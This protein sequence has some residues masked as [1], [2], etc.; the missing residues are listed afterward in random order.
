MSSSS[1]FAII[2]AAIIILGRIINRHAEKQ[3]NSDDASREFDTEHDF[4]SEDTTSAREVR[5]QDDDQ[6]TLAKVIREQIIEARKRVEATRQNH[7]HMPATTEGSATFNTPRFETTSSRREIIIPQSQKFKPQ[8]KK[9]ASKQSVSTTKDT[10]QQLQNS[11]TAT[12]SQTSDIAEEFDLVKAVIYA[13]ILN[14][15]FDQ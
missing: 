9:T 11:N 13:E 14:P 6:E 12:T 1:I 15:K 7:P 4:S 5:M 8:P 3:P 10:K 2:T